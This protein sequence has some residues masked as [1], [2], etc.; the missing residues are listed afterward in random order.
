[1]S[2][3]TVPP[4]LTVALC[5]GHSADVCCALA[6]CGNSAPNTTSTAIAIHRAIATRKTANFMI[7]RSPRRPPNGKSA[8]GEP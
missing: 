1:M 4:L 8:R 6:D 3:V 7:V 2:I 5:G